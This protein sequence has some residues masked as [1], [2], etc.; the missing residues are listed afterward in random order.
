MPLFGAHL[1]I[2]GGLPNAVLAAVALG[3]ETLQIFTRNPNSWK[4]KLLLDSEAEAFRKA[5][6]AANLQY[7]TSHDSYLIN[8]AAADDGL[9]RKSVDA[10]IEEVERAEKLGLAYVVTH[11][12]AHTGA[13]EDAGIARI[14]AALDEVRSRCA[15]SRVQILLE[16]TAGQGSYLGGRFEHLRRILDGVNDSRWLGVCVDTCH[17]FAAGYP[18]STPDEYRATIQEFEDAIGLDRLKLFHINDSAGAFNSRLD[19]HASL[20]EGKIGLD[21]FRCLVTD[22]R[23]ANHPMILETPKED[24]NG[25]EMDPVN[26]A[27]LFEFRKTDAAKA[28]RVRP[29]RRRG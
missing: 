26:L 12:G 6:A 4:A 9:F 5:V 3:C 25:R 24:E 8:L 10:F 11:P 1:S 18:I 7:V 20:G 19:R 15:G 16:T 22:P 23:F 28:A 21:L 2:A 27:K 14:V 13:G 29:S 17:I